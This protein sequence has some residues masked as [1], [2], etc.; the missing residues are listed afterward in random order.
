MHYRER[1]VAHAWRCVSR[2]NAQSWVYRG[3][4]RIEARWGNG[5]YDQ[6]PA[7]ANDLIQD[8]IALI[9][10]FTTPAGQ[11]AKAGTRTTPIVFTHDQ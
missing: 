5:R 6:F 7:V 3:H 10:A 4:F 8:D 1:G 9:A 11:A 2:R